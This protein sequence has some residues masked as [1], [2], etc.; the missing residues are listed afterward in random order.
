MLPPR[1]TPLPADLELEVNL[2]VV[3]VRH[4]LA[5]LHDLYGDFP[6]DIVL[7]LGLT[8]DGA[9]WVERGFQRYLSAVSD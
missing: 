3:Y 8:A 1:V 6:D 7:D 2:E 9:E 4:T 5:R